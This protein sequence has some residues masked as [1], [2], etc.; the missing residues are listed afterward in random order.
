LKTNPRNSSVSAK[1]DSKIDTIKRNKSYQYGSSSLVREKIRAVLEDNQKNSYINLT[2][3]VT[4]DR[5]SVIRTS[6]ITRNFINP[7]YNT[8]TSLKY[9]SNSTIADCDN[10]HTEFAPTPT[11][12]IMT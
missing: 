9:Y 11:Y 1:K 6:V 5:M 4:D 2:K 12:A 3:S 10:R 7:E 8:Q